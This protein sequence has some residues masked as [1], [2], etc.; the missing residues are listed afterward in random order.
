[1]LSIFQKLDSLLVA[2]RGLWCVEPFHQSRFDSLPWQQALPELCCWLDE[3]SPREIEHYKNDTQALSDATECFLPELNTIKRMAALSAESEVELSFPKGLNNGIPGRKLKQISA[4]GAFSLKHHTGSQWL[5]WCSGKGYL[6]RILAHHSGKPVTSFEWQ[7]SLCAAGQQ[8]ADAMSLPMTFIQGDALSSEAG[9]VFKKE[10]HAVALH[11][12][13]DL[14]VNL[15]KRV[16]ERKLPAVTISPCC[17]HLIQ[18]DHYQ[19]LSEAARS[20]ALSMTKPELSIPLQE[21]VTG[22]DR[23]KRHRHQEMVY[24][25]GLDLL[26]RAEGGQTEYQPVPSIKKSSLAAGFEHFCR[27]AADKKDFE[28]PQA[29]FAFWEKEG[30]KRFWQME[31]L[32]LV[33]QLFRRTLELW[34]VFDR[35][36]F[37][38]ENGYRVSV[39]EFCE[40]EVTPR[41]ILIHGEREERVQSASL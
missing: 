20:A 14:H 37:L 4:M 33:Q 9:Q 40:R 22:G 26:L 38:Q 23:V 25:L 6:G 11:A 17:Y 30:E 35:V 39:S 7:S 1:M 13:G 27:W 29:D 24:R 34:L 15:L 10:Q 31:K 32:S 3:L 19:P 5:E 16:V 21:T 2:H 28:L 12:C 8:E 36:L 18:S 41:N